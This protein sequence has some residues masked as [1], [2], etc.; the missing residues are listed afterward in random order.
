MRDFKSELHQDHINKFANPL[1]VGKL[2]ISEVSKFDFPRIKQSDIEGYNQLKA[3]ELTERMITLAKVSIAK[4]YNP[5]NLQFMD[6]MTKKDFIVQGPSML[7]LGCNTLEVIRLINELIKQVHESE[8]LSHIYKA[9]LRKTKQEWKI[10]LDND[11]SFEINAICKENLNLV[12]NNDG[13]KL[14]FDLAIKEF[15]KTLT[16]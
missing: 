11:L 8:I 7:V 10:T 2:D 15:D 4:E 1:L 12:D 6:D 5:P 13:S 16:S 3:D 14:P 9:Q